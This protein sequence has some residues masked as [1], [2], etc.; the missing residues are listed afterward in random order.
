[1]PSTITTFNTKKHHIHIEFYVFDRSGIKRALDGV[2]DTG[3][4]R[5]EFS[6]EF[7]EYANFIESS[8][9]EIRIKPGLQTQKYGK[10]VLPS[11]EIC[12]HEIKNFQVFASRFE[13]E[14]GIDALIGLDFFRQFDVTISYNRGCII[15]EKV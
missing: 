2:I 6:D 10:I 8:N 14:W 1:M 4:P 15:T 12:G 13:K 5:T 3:A 11:I 9:K 7:L